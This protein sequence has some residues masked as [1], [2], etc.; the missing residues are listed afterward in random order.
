MTLRRAPSLSFAFKR[1]ILAESR[2]NLWPFFHLNDQ[3]S[4]L[5][6]G[7]TAKEVG[8]LLRLLYCISLCTSWPWISD[9]NVT[10]L[11]EKSCPLAFSGFQGNVKDRHLCAADVTVGQD[12]WT[13]MA[14]QDLKQIPTNL[15]GSFLPPPKVEK[16][17]ALSSPVPSRD[18][19]GHQR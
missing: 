2:K 8:F 4:H 16:S 13:L 19:G 5:R 17:L 12:A 15:D 6:V 18:G 11:S 14:L 3:L 1:R 10:P 9:V 7:G